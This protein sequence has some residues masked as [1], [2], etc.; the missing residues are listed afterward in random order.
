MIT[1]F[2]SFFRALVAYIHCNKE[3]SLRTRLR[4]NSV[5][6]GRDRFAKKDANKVFASRSCPIIADSSRN[7]NRDAESRTAL[8]FARV[9]PKHVS[10]FRSIE[11]FCLLISSGARYQQ[12]GR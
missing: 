9:V 10:K 5:K 11:P 8:D 4:F 3:D 2:L 7:G 6:I 1:S 12:D